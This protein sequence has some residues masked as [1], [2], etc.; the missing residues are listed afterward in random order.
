MYHVKRGMCCALLAAS[1]ILTGC[2]GLPDSGG[3]PTVVGTLSRPETKPLDST[4]PRIIGVQ[5]IVVYAGDAVAYRQGIT[6]TDDTDL[7]PELDV[8]SSRVDQTTPG[9]YTVIYTASD[10]AGNTATKKATVTVLNKEQGYETLE[11]IYRAADTLLE[12]ILSVD[13]TARE[14]VKAVY[15]W[16]RSNIGYGGHSDRADWRQTAYTTMQELRGDCYGYFSV[17]KLLFERLNIP[18]IDVQ[19]VR[20]YDSDS[21]HFWSMVSVD[22]GRNWYHFDATPRVGDGDNFCLVTDE[23]LDAYSKDHKNC[24]NRDRSL[25]PPTPEE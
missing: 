11:T 3:E 17:T 7:Y 13:M 22:G 1:V 23:F 5:D 25:Y 24:H 14:Q 12:S 4:P 16:A 20:N 15:T 6:V 18:N 10:A 9:T 2:H 19:K 21:D 8:D